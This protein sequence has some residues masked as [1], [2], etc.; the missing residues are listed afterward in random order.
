[1][2]ASEARI[3]LIASGGNFPHRRYGPVTV[4]YEFRPARLYDR[5]VT[6]EEWAERYGQAWEDADEDAIAALFT[7][8]AVYRSAPFRE[9]FR[10]EAE[11]RGYWRRGAGVQKQVRVRMGTP[12]VDGERAAV[13]WWTTMYDPDDGEVTLPGCLLLRFASDGRCSELREYWHVQPGRHEP[14]DGWGS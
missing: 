8:D 14:H 12:F 9:P 1:M 7:E 11:L 6:V 10:G 3:L 2:G 5:L 13:E 4:L